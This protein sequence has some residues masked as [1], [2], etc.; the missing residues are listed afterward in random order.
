[1]I[2]AAWI[3]LL[4]PLVGALVI[5]LGGMRIPARVTGWIATA[6]TSVAFVG[7]VVAL[8]KLLGEHADRA[9]PPLDRRTRGSAQARTTSG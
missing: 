2:A 8:V 9:A 3:C 4:S 5:T 1:M 6:S 7:A